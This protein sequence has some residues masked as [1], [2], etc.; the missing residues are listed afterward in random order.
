MRL[1]LCAVVALACLTIFLPVPSARADDTQAQIA[2]L[3]RQIADLQT[4]IDAL[5]SQAG[6][7][8]TTLPLASQVTDLLV[9]QCG[10]SG[11]SVAFRSRT[12]VRASATS[13]GRQ[14][15]FG[16]LRSRRGGC[17]G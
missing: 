3:E 2:A 4:T 13:T 8:A 16:R 1:V 5:K 11:G 15:F 12:T 17:G 14:G 7:T 9:G 6:Q 10:S